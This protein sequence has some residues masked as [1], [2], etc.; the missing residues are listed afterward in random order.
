MHYS[1]PDETPAMAI[2]LAGE[3][4][5]VLKYVLYP[6]HVGDLQRQDRAE[7]LSS[8]MES[9]IDVYK[10]NKALPIS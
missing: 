2:G 5:T 3:A 1:L 4:R 7:Q 8:L 10:R 6:V 9:D